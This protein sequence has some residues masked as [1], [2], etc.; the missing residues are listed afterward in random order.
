MA[1]NPV[2]SQICPGYA[3]CRG[4][5]DTICSSRSS[6]PEVILVLE[7]IRYGRKAQMKALPRLS[8]KKRLELVHHILP[9]C[10][11]D[12]MGLMAI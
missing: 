7:G 3:F 10:H 12:N 2:T 5:V 4:R 9:V 6:A 11:P 1:G 8:Y